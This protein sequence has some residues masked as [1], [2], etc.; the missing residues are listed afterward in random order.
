MDIQK[1]FS[2]Q[3][4]KNGISDGNVRIEGMSSDPIVGPYL[5]MIL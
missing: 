2:I 3:F 1:L 4:I 5:D